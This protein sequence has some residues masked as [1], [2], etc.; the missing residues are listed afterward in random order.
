[1]PV[2]RPVPCPATNRRPSLAPSPTPLHRYRASAVAGWATCVGKRRQREAPRRSGLRHVL[3]QQPMADVQTDRA[4]ARRDGSRR[5]AGILK[6]PAGD[7]RVSGASRRAH[8]G[9][10][11]VTLQAAQVALNAPGG[12]AGRAT[13][14]SRVPFP[15]APTDLPQIS[16]PSMRPFR[17]AGDG[18]L[19]PYC[20]SCPGKRRGSLADA[21]SACCTH[22]VTVHSTRFAA[23]SRIMV[24]HP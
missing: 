11:F 19:D 2:R 13:R 4:A 10:Q 6:E 12:T 18:P 23:L 24:R 22:P 3:R 20:G 16:R 14:N 7:E 8:A 21:L 5:S 9:A 1:M 15:C 17:A